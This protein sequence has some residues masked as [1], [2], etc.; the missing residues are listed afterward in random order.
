[1][2]KYLI[3]I[4][5]ILATLLTVYIDKFCETAYKFPSKISIDAYLTFYEPVLVVI[6]LGILKKVFKQ[7]WVQKLI[8]VLTVILILYT[9]LFYGFILSFYTPNEIYD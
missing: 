4:Y 3:L 7:K 9:V 6:I 2:Y 1:M 8:L 5:F